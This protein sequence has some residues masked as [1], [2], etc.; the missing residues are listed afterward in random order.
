MTRI[1][2][3]WYSPLSWPA[4]LLIPFAFLF[5]L[6]SSLRR[7]LFRTGCYRQHKLPVPVIVV[8][9]LTVG[10]A[11]K[12]PL[13]Y[14]LAQE[15]ALRGWHPGIVSRG[16]GGSNLQPLEVTQQT[17]PA[18]CGD[19]PLLL[20]RTGLPVFVCPKRAMAAQALLNAHPEVNV[21]LC[22]DGLQHYA[23][24]RDIELCVVDGARMFG[25]RLLLPA[26]PLRE[27]LYRLRDV[28]AMIVNGIENRLFHPQQFQM[29]LHAGEFYR[30][31]DRS[32]YPLENLASAQLAAVCGIGNPS[33]F[34]TTLHQLGLRFGEYPFPDH[35]RFCL[36]DLPEADLILVTEKDAV[37]LANLPGIASLSA[38]ILVLPVSAQLQPDLTNWLEKRLQHGHKA[39]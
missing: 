4:L 7:E 20:A 39:A 12:T 27:P 13:T 9:N 24:A 33:R 35:H 22:D 6:A 18:L 21:L 15:L 14:Y 23:L 36:A 10:G 25:N 37:K 26:G 29:R 38:K 31:S 2:K 19:E 1:E 32:I 17:D 30:L 8:G 5:A 3:I 34:F 28:D 16:Y 11:G